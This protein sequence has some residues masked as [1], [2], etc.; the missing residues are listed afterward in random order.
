MKHATMR[1]H[2][3]RFAAAGMH[4]PMHRMR[5]AH[6]GMGPSDNVAA[7]LNQQELQRMSGSS[8]APAGY[9]AQQPGYNAPPP[10]GYQGR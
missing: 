9:P 5:G 8:M 10:L 2:H 4:H 7:Q 3:A 1:G 6:R